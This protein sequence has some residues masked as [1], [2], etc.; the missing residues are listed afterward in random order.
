MW[1]HLNQTSVVRLLAVAGGRALS[2][3]VLL[4]HYSPRLFRFCVGTF[5]SVRDELSFASAR[6]ETLIPGA[7]PTALL[8]SFQI[9]HIQDSCVA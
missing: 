8:H 2:Q 5:G 3:S 6:M 7:E 1:M 4:V 9:G